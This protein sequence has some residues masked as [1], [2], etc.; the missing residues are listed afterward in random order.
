M[1]HD[2]LPARVAALE[3]EVARIRSEAREAAGDAKAARYLASGADHDVT[4]VR[5]ELRAHTRVINALRE[6][7]VEFTTEMYA[8]RDEMY[9]Q[10]GTVRSG[11]DQIIG[12]ID[13]HPDQRPE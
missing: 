12:L 13:R 7:H 9:Q 11:I 8:F 6:D 5:D 10:L 4:A 3:S 1:P 2:D